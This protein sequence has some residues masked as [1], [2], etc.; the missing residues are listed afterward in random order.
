MPCAFSLLFMAGCA[1]TKIP[2]ELVPATKAQTINFLSGNFFKNKDGGDYFGPEGVAKSI[3]ADGNAISIG[4]WS[5]KGNFYCEVLTYYAPSNG[6]RDGTTNEVG[7]KKTCYVLYIIPEGLGD[8]KESAMIRNTSSGEEKY[9]PGSVKGF[10][11]LGTFNELR[12]KYGV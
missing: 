7:P 10:P 2:T 4:T 9:F 3:R 1:P 12:T 5:S 11:L 8:G 6:S